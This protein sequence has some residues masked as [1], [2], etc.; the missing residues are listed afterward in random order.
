MIEVKTEQLRKDAL[1]RWQ[2][3]QAELDA[4][5]TRYGAFET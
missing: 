3:A 2:L 1:A 4:A 5:K